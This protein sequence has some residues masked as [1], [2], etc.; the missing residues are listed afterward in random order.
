MLARRLPLAVFALAFVAVACA[1]GSPTISSGSPTAIASPTP[2]AT[3]APPPS[4]APFPSASPALAEGRSFG[5]IK[6]VDAASS[7]LVFDLAQIFTGDAA[8]KAAQEDGVIGPGESIDNDYY[9][10]NV[11]PKLRTV[12][13]SPAVQISII[14]WTNCCEHTLSP[15][16]AT[17][18]QA[19][20][21]PGP[22]DDFHGPTSPYWLTVR[23][24]AIVKV[25]EQYLA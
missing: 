12:P 24:G 11:N 5:Y 7:T 14:E 25:E 18:A 9:I 8:N 3:S 19:F 22:T 2:V 1:E 10:R 15:D 21:G 23:N 13:L 16:I 4:P 17:F 20:P 6:S